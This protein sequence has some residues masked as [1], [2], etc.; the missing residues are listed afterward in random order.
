MSLTQQQCD[1]FWASADKNGDG[2]LTIQELAAAVRQYVPQNPPPNYRAP[3]SQDVV[4]S[5]SNNCP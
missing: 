1:D 3:T 2:K 5:Y 4:V